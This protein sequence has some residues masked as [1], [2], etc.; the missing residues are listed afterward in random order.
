MS[1][2]NINLDSWRRKELFQHYKSYDN[3]YFN[4]CTS[5]DIKNFYR[6]V[7]QRRYPFS[8]CLLYICLRVANQQRSFRYRIR[9]EQ[10]HLLD[11]VNAAMTVLHPD[12][13]FDFCYF[14]YQAFFFD[15]LNA[16]SDELEL[17]RSQRR[18]LH[19]ADHQEDAI[20][21][22]ILPWI[23]FTN[24]RNAYDSKARC[25]TPKIIFGKFEAH[26]NRLVLP[27]AIEAHHALVD[28]I[29]VAQ[30]LEEVQNYLREPERAISMDKAQVSQTQA[31]HEQAPHA[32]AL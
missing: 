21:F 9:G 16:A 5:L 25:S 31:S 17:H 32:V 24:L 7:K 11:Q 22:A 20:H 13:Y 19:H 4:I 3:P 23:H 15:Y 1:L 28:G 14:K 27:V 30:F 2:T 18:N 8:L 10:V 26:E 12:D 29:H 6:Y